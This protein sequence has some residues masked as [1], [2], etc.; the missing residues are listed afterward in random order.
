M[1]RRSL[2]HSIQNAVVGIA[3]L[4]ELIALIGHPL[5]GWGPEPKVYEATPRPLVYTAPVPPSG[6]AILLA[7]AAAAARQPVPARAAPPSYAYVE[8]ETWHLAARASGQPVSSRALPALIESWL[9]PDGSGR[10][11]T[12]TSTGR[13]SRIDDETIT[14][15][16]PLPR[17]T[18]NE[19]AL[20]DALMPGHVGHTVPAAEF[21]AITT[22]A[23]R[24]PIPPPVQAALLRLLARLRGL[25]NSGTVIDRDGR[26]GAAVSLDSAYTGV[27]TGYTLIFDQL[28]GGLLDAEQTLIGNPP[29]SLDVQA[30]AILAYTTF[31]A[32]GHVISTTARP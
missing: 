5:F 19:A 12:V 10:L 21:V 29:P 13:R 1:Q 9:K 23:D 8:R 28:T 6:H 32:S 20:A 24:Q 14:A 25:I 2:N 15:A 17:L 30:G 31:L 27:M 18:A 26:P 11:L 4:A 22:V 16:A 3:L 7:L